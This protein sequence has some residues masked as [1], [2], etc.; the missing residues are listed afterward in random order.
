MT[1][2]ELIEE[3]RERGAEAGKLMRTMALSCSDIDAPFLPEWSPL[4]GEWAGESAPE[5]LGDLLEECAGIEDD[6][7]MQEEEITDAYET[8]ALDAYYGEEG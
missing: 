3:A 8:A 4:S 7:G 2:D 1:I 6:G 5:L